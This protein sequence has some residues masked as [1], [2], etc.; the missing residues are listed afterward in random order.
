MMV[1][2]KIKK[3]TLRVVRYRVSRLVN[4]CDVTEQHIW[5]A[6]LQYVLGC[7][8]TGVTRRKEYFRYRIL[9]KPGRHCLKFGLIVNYTLILLPPSKA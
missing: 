2:Q 7:V 4:N 8:Y 9:E 1:S 6:V 3:A 5:A